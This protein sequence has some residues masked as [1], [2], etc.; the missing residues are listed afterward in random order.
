MAVAETDPGRTATW[1]QRFPI[2]LERE[3]MHSAVILE[4]RT[5]DIPDAA[6][7]DGHFVV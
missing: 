1:W 7:M 3:Y 6:V 2:P 4:G 5:V